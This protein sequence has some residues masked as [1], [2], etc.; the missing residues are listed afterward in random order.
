MNFAEAK[1][2]RDRGM[3]NKEFIDYYYDDLLKS[4]TLVIVNIDDQ[5]II[6]TYQ[7]SNS[8]LTTVGMLEVAKKQIL[9]DMETY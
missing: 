8:Q 2:K 4:Q 9:E 6:N 5:N 7:T 3:S 1:R